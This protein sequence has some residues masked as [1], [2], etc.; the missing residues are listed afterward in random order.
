MFAIALLLYVLRN[1]AGKGAWGER[2]PP[3]AFWGLN[4]GLAGMRL[5]GRPRPRVLPDPVFIV[6]GAVPIAWLAIR[7][8]L[9]LGGRAAVKRGRPEALRQ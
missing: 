1:L 4:A 2:L 5:L 9:G 8:F 7:V 3:V 6:L